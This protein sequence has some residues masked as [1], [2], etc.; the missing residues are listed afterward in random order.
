MDHKIKKS[1]ILFC[2]SLSALTTACTVIEK[3]ENVPDLPITAEWSYYSLN[4]S[5]RKLSDDPDSFPKFWSDDGETCWISVKGVDH[6][7]W[8][9]RQEDGSYLL[10]FSEDAQPITA[11]IDGDILTLS[12]W[13]EIEY[14]FMGDDE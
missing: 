2:L 14:A 3:E 4:D 9:I 13:G 11:K 1:L 7:G 6:E 8:M 10:Y 12:F 5:Y